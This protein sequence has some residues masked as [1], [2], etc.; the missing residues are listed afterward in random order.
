MQLRYIQVDADPLTR[1]QLSQLLEKFDNLTNKGTFSNA[2]NTLEYLNFNTV[3][4]IFLASR[5][6]DYS[7]FEFIEK[8]KDSIPIILIAKEPFDAFKAF[9]YDLLDC[10]SQP[11]SWDR[12]KKSIQRL[13]THTKKQASQKQTETRYLAIKSDFKNEKIDLDRIQFIQAA[14]DYIKIITPEK[15]FMVHSTM[16]AILTKLPEKQF[17]R[18]HK[19]YI[20]NL[21]YVLHFTANA[22]MIPGKVLPLSRYQ[23]KQFQKQF[24]TFQ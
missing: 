16:K 20:V 18:I 17:Q 13:N 9:E 24:E 6:P 1:L 22:I 15:S 2:S 23:K 11:V 5:L 12:I 10:I 7:G 4:V 14:G 3:D 21:K 19:S 8:V